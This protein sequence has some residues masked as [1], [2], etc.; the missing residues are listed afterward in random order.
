MR[1]Y[2]INFTVSH[3]RQRYWHSNFEATKECRRI[4]SWISQMLF[5]FNYKVWSTSWHWQ[6]IWNCWRILLFSSTKKM[7]HEEYNL[8]FINFADV[9]HTHLKTVNFKNRWLDFKQFNTFFDAGNNRFNSMLT[10]RSIQHKQALKR[11]HHK[12]WH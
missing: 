11:A 2:N 12:L 8:H 4:I 1:Y 7:F 9:N 3:N 6:K 10:E 5:Q